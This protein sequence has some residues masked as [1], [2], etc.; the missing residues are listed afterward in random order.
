MHINEDDIVLFLEG[1]LSDEDHNELLNHMNECNECYL[2]ITDIAETVRASTL[3][4]AKMPDKIYLSKANKAAGFEDYSFF[5]KILD[6]FTHGRFKFALTGIGIVIA[7]FAFYLNSG[8]SEK[9][10]FRDM[11]GKEALQNCFAS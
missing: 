7:L 8:D 6:L 4:E 11:S 2:K 5:D 1:L 10:V 9:A 3:A